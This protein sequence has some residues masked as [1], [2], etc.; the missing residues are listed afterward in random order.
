[1]SDKTTAK[2]ATAVDEALRGRPQ[3]G[4]RAETTAAAEK[5]A[6]GTPETGTPETGKSEAGGRLTVEQRFQLVEA[7]LGAARKQRDQLEARLKALEEAPE[8]E[9]PGQ[10]EELRVLRAQVE[11]LTR[12]TTAQPHPSEGARFG[13]SFDIFTL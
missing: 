5:P 7:E 10:Q 13:L 3:R 8:A 11:D 9:A 6:T 2:A 1:M 12:R 4:R